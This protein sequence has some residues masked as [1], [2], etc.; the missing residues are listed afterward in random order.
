MEL[1]TNLRQI[2]NTYNPVLP[3]QWVM[4]W[5]QNRCG[6]L[7]KMANGFRCTTK[8]NAE[9]VVNSYD[10]TVNISSSDD[11]ALLNARNELTLALWQL[12]YAIDEAIGALCVH[13]DSYTTQVPDASQ[14]PNDTVYRTDETRPNMRELTS[15]EMFI[16]HTSVRELVQ[17]FGETKV[18]IK[19]T[20]GDRKHLMLGV[21]VAGVD[22][23]QPQCLYVYV[24]GVRGFVSYLIRDFLDMPPQLQECVQIAMARCCNPQ[25]RLGWDI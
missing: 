16:M 5:M 24:D 10:F 14:L 6:S 20:G 3:V 9:I 11:I 25:R 19:C 23:G 2:C 13:R 4:Y 7:T 18:N 1:N 8:N 21:Y 12:N 17:S 15:L 22:G